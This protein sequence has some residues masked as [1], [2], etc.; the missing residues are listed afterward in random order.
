MG[1]WFV[2][3]S[4]ALRLSGNGWSR[5]DGRTS[6]QDVIAEIVA[7]EA[8]MER[9]I[10]S[11]FD[12][13]LSFGRDRD[14]LV[15]LQLQPTPLPLEGEILPHLPNVLHTEDRREVVGF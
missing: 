7:L 5:G 11:S 8:K 14:G 10:E 4:S 15:A 3:R 9:V 6:G 1:G 2:D 13:H 12:E